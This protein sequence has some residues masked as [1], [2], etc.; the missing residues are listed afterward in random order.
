[1]MRVPALIICSF[2]LFLSLPFGTAAQQTPPDIRPLLKSLTQTQKIQVQEYLRHLGAN[3][4]NEIQH[5]YQQTT[6]I[7]QQKA[8]RYVEILKKDPSQI[9]LAHIKWNR[10]TLFFDDLI[11]G[12]SLI[13]SIQVTNTGDT[14]YLIHRAKATCDCTVLHAPKYLLMP[15]ETAVLR[16]EF[17]SSGK[18]GAVMPAII[19]YDNSFPNKRSILYL[20][21]N[22]SA[23]KK[24][25]KY[26]WED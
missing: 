12:S 7:N 18:L 14:P 22:V 3:L 6:S 5:A 19:I 21:G 8:I 24:L 26:P 15:G 10:D 2:T 11:E 25:R 20:K 13:D 1:M 17:D 9:P 16:L 4:E 23:R